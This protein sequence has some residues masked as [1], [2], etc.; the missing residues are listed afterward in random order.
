M[1]LWDLLITVILLGLGYWALTFL[2]AK[3]PEP[4]RTP[5]YVVLVVIA[6]VYV[7]A[8]MTGH[9]HLIHVGV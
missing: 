1:N 7:V 2:V 8:L 6:I 9:A 3:L 4:M 5:A